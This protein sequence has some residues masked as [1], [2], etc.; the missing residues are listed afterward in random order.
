MDKVSKARALLTEMVLNIDIAK[1]SGMDDLHTL[2]ITTVIADLLLYYPDA[3]PA[4][5][6]LIIS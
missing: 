2:Q 1:N 4:K 3:E 6:A 5:R